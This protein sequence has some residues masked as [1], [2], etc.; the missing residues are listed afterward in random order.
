MKTAQARWFRLQPAGIILW[1]RADTILRFTR[2][3]SQEQLAR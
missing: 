2:Q 3:G 1:V